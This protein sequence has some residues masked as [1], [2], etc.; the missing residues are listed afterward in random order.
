MQVQRLAGEPRVACMA[1]SDSL[2]A[3]GPLTLSQLAD[4]PH[5][6]WSPQV[7]RMWQDFW[8]ADPR[9]DGSPV[10]DTAHRVAD[11]ETALSAIS[12]GEES[13]SRPLPHD[14]CI[15][16]PGWPTSM[17]STSAPA[18]SSSPGSPGIVTAPWLRPCGG[19]RVRSSAAGRRGP[20]GALAH[21][22]SHAR[23]TWLIWLT[24]LT[25]AD[26]AGARRKRAGSVRPVEAGSGG[27]VGSP[28]GGGE[29]GR[30]A[31]AAMRHT[32]PTAAPFPRTAPVDGV[33]PVPV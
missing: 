2:A 32:W 11:F 4:R 7:P 27:R 15:R 1:D 18:H 10:R 6:G 30:P 24:R 33:I 25:P 23:L 16:A 13:S 19:P 17:S 22:Y 29:S 12:L 28:V 31:G 21:E 3:Q 20:T 9:P 8:S 5:I 14:I 26:A